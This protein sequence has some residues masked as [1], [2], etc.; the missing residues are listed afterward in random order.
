MIGRKQRRK[1]RNRFRD[2]WPRPDADGIREPVMLLLLTPP[3]SGSTAIANFL[4]QLPEISALTA[5][6]E[7]QELIRGMSLGGRWAPGKKI[8]EQSIRAVWLN[9]VG[10]IRAGGEAADFIIEKSPPNMMRHERIA[11]LFAGTRTVC[12]IRNPY[13][14]VSSMVF[15]YSA[16][17]ELGKPER[18]AR[19]R[20]VAGKWIRRAEVL[21]GILDRNDYPLVTYEEFCAD[22]PLIFRAFGFDEDVLAR[23][24]QDA[25]VKVKDHAR[26]AVTNMNARQ[27]ARLDAAELDAIR[28]VLAA[29]PELPERF[30]YGLDPQDA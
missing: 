29:R 15:R 7:G 16:Y 11:G 14:N 10:R 27:V 30:G 22:P 19:L 5:R 18:L 4:C 24:Q 13:A 3:N 12:N 25:A 9:R 23:V 1:L 2:A 17:E 8:D 6:A 28:G 21:G 20:E 26:Q